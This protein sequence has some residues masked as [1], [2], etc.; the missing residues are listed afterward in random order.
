MNQDPD[1]LTGTPRRADEVER[2]LHL[3]T[4]QEQETS[5]DF[6]AK[7]QRMILRRSA[8]SQYVS[9][10]WNMPKVV[11]VELAGILRHLVTIFDGKRDSQS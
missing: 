7:V 8:A 9:F 5:P 4:E 2:P 10:S 6:V 11:L 3:L 1:D